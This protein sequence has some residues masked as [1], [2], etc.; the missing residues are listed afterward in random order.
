MCTLNIVHLV[1]IHHPYK[2]I[3]QYQSSQTFCSWLANLH[4]Y[5]NTEGHQN[6]NGL[7]S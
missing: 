5:E 2:A 1:I 3:D 4:C 7:D 6:K